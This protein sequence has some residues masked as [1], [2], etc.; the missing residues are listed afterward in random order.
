MWRPGDGYHLRGQQ[1]LEPRD[2]QGQ[3]LPVLNFGLRLC[4]VTRIHDW[5]DSKR[6]PKHHPPT[7]KPRAGRPI[8]FQDLERHPWVEDKHQKADTLSSMSMRPPRHCHS[9]HVTRCRH[10][11]AL[12][13][14]QRLGNLRHPTIMLQ[15]VKLR[16][17]LGIPLPSSFCGCSR[18]HGLAASLL[19]QDPV[20]PRS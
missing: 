15:R 5:I 2:L 6:L 9:P 12:V 7:Q 8:E 13:A 16:R 3:L 20:Q 18:S 14:G 4:H 1:P 19:A 10:F 11:N 17:L